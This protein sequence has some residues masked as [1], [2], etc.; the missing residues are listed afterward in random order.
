L[1][2]FSVD[3][4]MSHAAQAWPSIC[5][6]RDLE[7]CPVSPTIYLANLTKQFLLRGRTLL[8]R[9]KAMSPLGG[10]CSLVGS[11]VSPELPDSASELTI[12]RILIG[13]LY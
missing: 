13:R 10:G 3:S 7:R 1:V 4:I 11:Y 8:V 12:L 6:P 5:F 9:E 2:L